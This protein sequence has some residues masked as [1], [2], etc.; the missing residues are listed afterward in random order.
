MSFSL[1]HVMEDD[2]PIFFEQQSDPEAI[3][4][5]AFTPRD[6]GDRPAFLARWHRWLADPTI[7]ARTIVLDGGIVGYVMSYEEDGK[8]E[9]TY[10]LGRYYWGQGLATRALSAFLQQGN[11]ARPIFARCAQ[12]HSASARILEKCG[13]A[14]ISESQGFANARNAEIAEWLW[15]LPE[16]ADR[17]CATPSTEK[18]DGP[19]QA[20]TGEL[21]KVYVKT[22]G[23]RRSYYSW[24]E[25]LLFEA[26][27]EP[28]NYFTNWF[29]RL[30]KVTFIVG[31]EHFEITSLAGRRAVEV[32][33]GF[34]RV[35]FLEYAKSELFTQC[36]KFRSFD[37]GEVIAGTFATG[38][39]Y[40][41]CVHSPQ[42]WIFDVHHPGWSDLPT[43]WKAISKTSRMAGELDLTRKHDP[44]VAILFMY[45]HLFLLPDSGSA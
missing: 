19:Q 6:P 23:N 25:E 40:W 42:V 38:E 22:N 12:D 30:Q 36:L 29:A 34:K 45:I 8:P 5:A 17:N 18:T 9:V 20:P 14:V 24:D 11:P 4:M 44:A 39:P 10:W 43:S 32:M 37:R 2:L 16:A 31:Q 3:H 26:I 13:F 27:Y 41:R 7:I 28:E 1:R 33:Q 15:Q 35:A 21:T